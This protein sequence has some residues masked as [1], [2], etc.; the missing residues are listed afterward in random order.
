M[1]DGSVR[2]NALINEQVHDAKGNE[3]FA[4]LKSSG[5]TNFMKEVRDS[6]NSFGDSLLDSGSGNKTKI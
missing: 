3:N 5:E 6:D 2:E 1:G 4:K